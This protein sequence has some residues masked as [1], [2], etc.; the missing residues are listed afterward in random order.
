MKTI[1]SL[2]LLFFGALPAFPQGSLTP[3]PGAP[4]PTMK[5]L[6]QVEP[7]KIVNAANTPGD[8]NYQFIIN[9]PGSYYLSGNL[10]GVSGKHGIA[11]NADGVTLDLNGFALIGP[12]GSFNGISVPGARRNLRIHNGAASGWAIGIDCMNATNS[13][14]DHLRVSQNL[15]GFRCGDGGVLSEISADANTVGPGIQTGSRCTLSVCQASNN[16]NN[17][18]I[19][20]GDSCTLTASI[21]TGNQLGFDV[22]SH[23]IVTGCTAV[24]NTGS[25]GGFAPTSDCTIKDCVANLNTTGI[26]TFGPN[27]RIEGNHC[28]GNTSYG[29]RSFSGTADWIM[30]NTCFENGGAANANPPANANYYPSSGAFFGPLGAP[31][32]ATSAWAN[33]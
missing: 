18:G 27:N 25:G 4:A 28:I 16:T 1:A 15:A 30:R 10:T 3:P 17:D 9:A 6:D 13:Q 11:I 22:Q 19:F 2:L 33:F 20:A 32:S 26:R 29:I 8:A 31:G 23:C 5:A 24:S 12:A 7:R 21:A 14:F